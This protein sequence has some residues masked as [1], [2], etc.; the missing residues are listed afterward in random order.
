MEGPT[1]VVALERLEPKEGFEPSTDGLRIRIVARTALFSGSCSAPMNA[2]A[3]HQ[4]GY[5]EGRGLY[6]AVPG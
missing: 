2:T 6:G 1:S 3:L 4:E 5:G